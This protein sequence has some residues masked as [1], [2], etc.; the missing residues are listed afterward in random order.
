MV[1]QILT[2]FWVVQHDRN[3]V[4]A[5]NVFVSDS[6]QLQKAGGVHGSSRQHYFFVAEYFEYFLVFFLR[7]FNSFGRSCVKYYSVHVRIG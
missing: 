2:Y 6:T 5:K 1:L 4:F 3:H 7:D